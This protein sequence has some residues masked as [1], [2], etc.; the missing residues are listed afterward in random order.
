M[1]ERRFSAEQSIVLLC[2]IEGATGQGKSTPIAC[3]EVGI[4]E[5][6]FRDDL[7]LGCC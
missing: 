5:Q 6:S 3:R 4:S 7:L 1:P 2:Q